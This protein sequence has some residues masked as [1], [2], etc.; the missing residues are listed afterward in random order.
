M[1][2]INL[3]LQ[4]VLVSM[5]LSTFTGKE[6]VIFF[7]VSKIGHGIKKWGWV[8]TYS[9]SIF[10]GMNIQLYQLFWG[11]LGARVLT[12]SHMSIH[13]I[14]RVQKNVD[15]YPHVKNLVGLSWEAN[16]FTSK[17]YPFAE[18]TCEFAT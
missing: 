18:S 11:S 15:L 2:P 13:I 14:L 7:R 3:I 5:G 16:Y 4:F 8:K 9:H 10:S 12:H 1:V 17:C 6:F